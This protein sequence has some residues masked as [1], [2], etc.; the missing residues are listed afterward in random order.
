MH[1]KTKIMQI[2]KHTY[3][4]ELQKT[5]TG[6]TNTTVIRQTTSN[7]TLQYLSKPA[8]SSSCINQRSLIRRNPIR[9][10]N[11]YSI[12]QSLTQ[13]YTKY[14]VAFGT[15]TAYTLEWMIQR[16]ARLNAFQRHLAILTLNTGLTHSTNELLIK[17]GHRVLPQSGRMGRG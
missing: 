8:H 1:L 7:C 3:Y 5:L 17:S 14:A 9:T 10:T 12:L 2:N 4:R 15:P 13:W 16:I 11:K 6:Y